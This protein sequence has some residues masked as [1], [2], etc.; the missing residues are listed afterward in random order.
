MRIDKTE[1][2]GHIQY[3]LYVNSLPLVCSHLPFLGYREIDQRRGTDF[4][5]FYQM[6]DTLLLHF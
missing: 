4:S 6:Y 5:Y 2:Q 1:Q 3:Q